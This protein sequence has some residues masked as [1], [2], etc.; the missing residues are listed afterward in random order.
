MDKFK[1][2]KL[3]IESINTIEDYEIIKRLLIPKEDHD[4]FDYLDKSLNIDRKNC[5]IK[6]F[7]FILKEI[8]ELLNKHL[9]DKSLNSE[10]DKI[11]QKFIINDQNQIKCI[12]RL[13]SSKKLN[14]IS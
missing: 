5:G 6:T 3:I 13:I 4:Y 14:F 8:N 11:K 2:Y 12:N 1:K 7:E 10:I 9:D